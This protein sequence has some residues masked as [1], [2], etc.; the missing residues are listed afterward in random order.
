MSL[1]PSPGTTRPTP[2]LPPPEARRFAILTCMDARLDPTRLLGVPEGSAHIIR[3]AGGRAS[4][5]AIQSLILSAQLLG[6]REWF[7]IHHTECG[8]NLRP[9]DLEHLLTQAAAPPVVPASTY[10]TFTHLMA[11]VA[12]D[13]DRIRQHPATPA[14]V[15]VYGY[16]YD[17]KH[18]A[19]LEAPAIRQPLPS[20]P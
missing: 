14:D 9:Q 1:L 18:N 7:V 17:V 12:A 16:V 5:D 8:V 10:P 13:L 6:T 20:A 11:T 2:P 3:N 19:L 15:L 4:D